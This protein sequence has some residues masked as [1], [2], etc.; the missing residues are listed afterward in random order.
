MTII[1][2]SNGPMRR[3]SP[4]VALALGR[5]ARSSHDQRA[6]QED[7]ARGQLGSRHAIEHGGQGGGADLPC[8]L[9]QGGQRHGEEARV[10]HVVDPDQ[11]D[12]A[13]H[14]VAELEQ[15]AHQAR[16]RPVVRAHDRVGLDVHERAHGGGIRG[17]EAPHQRR[18][19]G[20]ASRMERF[21]VAGLACFDGGGGVADADEPDPPRSQPQEV[22]GDEVPGAPVVDADE[23]VVPAPRVG[24]DRPVEQDDRDARVVEGLRDAAV[25]L[26]LRGRELERREEDARHL[27]VDVMAAELP[28][29]LFLGQA[30]ALRAV[31]AGHAAPDERMLAGERRRHH[32]LADRLEDLRLAEV[33]DQESEGE[34]GP[35][36]LGA[37]ERAR[38]GP[39]LD[40]SG[41][42]EVPHRA[43]H[44]DARG[45]VLTDEVGLAGEA[46]AFLPPAGL[47]LALEGAI[48]LLIFGCRATFRP[49][50]VRMI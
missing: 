2:A 9:T 21:P 47:D 46:V 43:A 8:G 12:L 30:F 38:A 11:A 20:H 22:L 28:G 26:V 1:V 37:D 5:A 48:D 7:V 32:A 39:P 44:G 45:A 17:V 34:R 13:R 4:A 36:V 31:L 33:G 42:L 27:P 3:A 25:D 24:D 18:H 10:V 35:A 19:V 6:V 15:R 14:R 41:T 49:C 23:V 16:R 50:H 29:A 40:E